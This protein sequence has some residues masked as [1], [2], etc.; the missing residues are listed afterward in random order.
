MIIHYDDLCFNIVSV[1]KINYRNV[2]FCDYWMEFA[3]GPCKSLQAI[4]SPRLAFK[5]N[6]EELHFDDEVWT[7]IAQYLR[8]HNDV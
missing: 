6:M 2:D 7:C 4:A 3:W 5:V 1:F 8:I